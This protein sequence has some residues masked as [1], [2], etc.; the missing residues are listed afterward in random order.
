MYI[1]LIK[2][3]LHII[4]LLANVCIILIFF[5]VFAL[6]LSSK[7]LSEK[8]F[9]RRME[10]DL[11]CDMAES[12]GSRDKLIESISKIDAVG[13]K[14]T[15]CEIFNS[16]LKGLSD[17]SPYWEEV[18]FNP[19]KYE[20][21]RDAVQFS[22]R[23]K[24]DL[25]YDAKEG[26]ESHILHIYFR[27]IFQDTKEPLLVIVGVS[28][29]SVETDIDSGLDVGMW[30]IVSSVAISIVLFGISTFRKVRKRG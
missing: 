1:V 8:V 22:S 17:R 28:K 11:I 24:F 19:L 4:V 29:Y 6:N 23:G 16:N 21:F 7:F 10:I 5:I 27:W 30:L 15:Y 25:W 9:D 26:G 18:L 2:K 12:G 14:G 20:D 13:G 3:N